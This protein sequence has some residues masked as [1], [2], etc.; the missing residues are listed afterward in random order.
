MVKSFDYPDQAMRKSF[1]ILE[2][3]ILF[4]S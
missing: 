2:G 4:L 3:L 1:D